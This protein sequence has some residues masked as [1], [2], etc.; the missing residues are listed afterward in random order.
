[1]TNLEES[2]LFKQDQLV[3]ATCHR[4]FAHLLLDLL[5]VV[6]HVDQDL[7]P[8]DVET[9]LPDA[10]GLE[11]QLHL[12]VLDLP[13]QVGPPLL[14][15]SVPRVALEN[16]HLV[17]EH[18]DFGLGRLLL[19]DG[20]AVLEVGVF[21]VLLG[22]GNVDDLDEE[23]D[24]GEDLGFL[25][26]ELL[27]EELVLAPAVPEV[28]LLTAKEED[29]VRIVL[30]CLDDFEQVLRLCVRKDHAPHGCFARPRLAHQ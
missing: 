21:L 2:V 12:Q 14:E 1:V 11:D 3:R 20:E 9:L 15:L 23:G 27:F 7:A 5:L 17:D 19:E 28:H 8:G 16:V 30:V 13:L 18:V 10:G 22:G 6:H 26:V 24:V 29:G 4:Q 25:G